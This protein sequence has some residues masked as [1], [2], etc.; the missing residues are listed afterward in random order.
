MGI[1]SQETPVLRMTG[2]IAH[3]G[4]SSGGLSFVAT[5][6]GKIN[7]KI[8]TF[9][10]IQL[11]NVPIELDDIFRSWNPQHT[12]TVDGVPAKSITVTEL[13][14]PSEWRIRI[15]RPGFTETFVNPAR[16]VIDISFGPPPP[17]EPVNNGPIPTEDPSNIDP[18]NTDPG[19]DRGEEEEEDKAR[20]GFMV[21]L[22]LAL[23][24]AV[25]AVALLRNPN[26]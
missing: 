8:S 9:G 19:I 1:I 12:G 11:I 7:N 17:I 5:L 16:A 10:D 14:D 21:S 15:V 6:P 20:I 2:D 25:F 23:G 3:V 22:L 13:G 26:K 24:V 4:P 18:V